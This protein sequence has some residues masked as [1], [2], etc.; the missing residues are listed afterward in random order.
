MT[1]VGLL[2]F[3]YCRIAR[4]PLGWARRERLYFARL[5]RLRVPG[6]VLGTTLF[7]FYIDVVDDK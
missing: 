4:V 2:I 7:S 3:F 6:A 1:G 5:A